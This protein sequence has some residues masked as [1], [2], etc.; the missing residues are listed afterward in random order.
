MNSSA[1]A[2]RT[3][4]VAS[5][6][7]PGIRRP[8][9]IRTLRSRG[10]ALPCVL[11]SFPAFGLTGSAHPCELN[12]SSKDGTP[13]L[14]KLFASVSL[15]AHATLPPSSGSI[16][17]ESTDRLDDLVTYQSQSS[18]RLQTIEGVDTASGQ[19]RGE[20]DWR[21]KG[22]LKIASSTGKCWA[23][24]KKRRQGTNGSSPASRRQCSLLLAWI[25]T[26]ET[27]VAFRQRL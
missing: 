15:Q 8:S 21:G 18:T 24:E 17:A 27:T 19:G 23:G 16:P 1:G 25:C 5:T 10:V 20:W 11:N 26:R 22:W 13:T 3:S 12:R 7:Y 14:W 6:S 9:L 2:Y 4:A